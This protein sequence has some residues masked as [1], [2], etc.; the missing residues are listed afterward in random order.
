MFLK[1][2][3]LSAVLALMPLLKQ[4]QVFGYNSF[5][6]NVLENIINTTFPVDLKTVTTSDIVLVKCP[7]KDYKHRY[8]F[9][10]FKEENEIRDSNIEKI[11]LRNKTL[12]W[13]SLL[14]ELSNSA[15][16]ICGQ[17]N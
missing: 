9:D 4:S 3:L 11:I 14:R 13:L 2:Y 1:L 6:P 10:M 8:N 15:H 16:L 5:L 12:I 17:I 7:Y